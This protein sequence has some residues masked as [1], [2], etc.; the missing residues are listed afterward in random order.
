MNQQ[1]NSLR[2][3]SEIIKDTL[4]D[5][6]RRARNGGIV[7]TVIATVIILLL[8][9]YPRSAS[10]QNSGA[11]ARVGGIVV[12][13]LIFACPPL[14]FGLYSLRR[15]RRIKRRTDTLARAMTLEPQLIKAIFNPREL[16]EAQQAA[17]AATTVTA[18]AGAANAT[19]PANASD[20]HFAEVVIEG[21]LASVLQVDQSHQHHT[22]RAIGHSVGAA[23]A[24]DNL[25]PDSVC[26]MLQDNERYF[27]YSPKVTK[28]ELF[29]ALR[30]HAPHAAA[31]P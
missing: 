25:P 29:Q 26:V 13:F 2:G 15:A 12:F 24:G 8:T 19:K 5:M 22:S 27:P 7:A 30:A 1:T 23:T 10:Y 3:A 11:W 14:V 31:Q 9:Q 28:A 16:Y 21:V 4:D 6:R 20:N 17:Q 18:N